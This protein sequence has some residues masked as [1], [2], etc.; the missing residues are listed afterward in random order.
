[1]KVSRNLQKVIY[2]TPEIRAI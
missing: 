1:M 2:I